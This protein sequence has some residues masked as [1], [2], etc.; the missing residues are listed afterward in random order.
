MQKNKHRYRFQSGDRRE[1]LTVFDFILT[2]L[3]MTGARI[4]SEL[5]VDWIKKLLKKWR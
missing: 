4:L 2:V 1:V 5:A 3:E